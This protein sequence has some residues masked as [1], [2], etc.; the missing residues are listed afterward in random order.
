MS[1]KTAGTLATTTL[2]AIQWYPG[3]QSTSSTNATDFATI[4]NGVFADPGPPS[5]SFYGNSGPDNEGMG[6]KAAAILPGAV[7]PAGILTLPGGRGT[8]QLDPGDWIATDG[9]GNLFPIPQRALPRTTTL[10]NCTTV[11]GSPAIAFASDC[12]VL[13]WQNGTHITGTNVPSNSIIGDLSSTGLTA[14]LYSAVTGLK[15]NAT[16]SASN[17]TLTAGTFTHS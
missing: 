2:T 10:A 11:T 7:S 17:T 5:G 14:N 8:I 13:G 3:F 9:F 1:T 4:A 16:G 6:N 15:V 12:R